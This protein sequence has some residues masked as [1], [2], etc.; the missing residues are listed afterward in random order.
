[1]FAC[2]GNN[3]V[4]YCDP[5]GEFLGE[6]IK[7]IKSRII[8]LF[9]TIQWYF[10]EFSNDEKVLIA[11]IAAEGTVTAENKPVS[12]TARQAMANVALNRVG[13]R[14]WAQY[15]SVSEIC[16][17]SGFDGY[18]TYNYFACMEYL[19]NRDFLNATYE[20]IIWDVA[21][22]YLYDV[23]GGCQLYYTPAVMTP[24]GSSPSWNFSVLTEV[25]ISGVDPY[26]E[27]RFYKYS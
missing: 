27:G 26:Y 16:R 10:G 17:Y 8:N 15:K 6:A 4:L 23:T 1:M 22:A 5:T 18:N 25:T 11:T 2:C 24:P 21:R 19:N 20:A 7:E 3:P 9:K 13:K 12:P 14:E